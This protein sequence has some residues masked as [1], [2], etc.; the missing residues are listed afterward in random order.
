VFR[1]FFI[2]FF[3]PCF[4]FAPLP[5][6]TPFLFL[7]IVFYFFSVS[8]SPFIDLYGY[9]FFEIIHHP[10]EESKKVGFSQAIP[11]YKND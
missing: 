4:L 1:L 6:V 2:L 7:V 11:G 5:L 8:V 9:F 10:K 3:F